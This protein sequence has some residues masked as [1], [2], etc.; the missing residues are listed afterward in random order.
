MINAYNFEKRRV[1]IFDCDGVLFDSKAS[2]INYYN[3]LLSKFGLPPLKENDVEFIHMH[4]ADECIYHLFSNSPH[5]KD[6]LKYR[7]EMP[8]DQFIKD[9]VMEDG[10]ID[11]L[12]FLKPVYHI[13]MATNRSNSIPEVLSYFKL[14]NFFDLVVSSLDVANPKPDPECI[15][16]II[17]FF[18]VTKEDVVYI[19][20]SKLDEL[21]AINAGVKFIAYKNPSLHADFHA[22]SLY[23]VKEII[24]KLLPPNDL[25]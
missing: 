9:M 5:L 20:D 19:G 2:N 18:R 11:L 12:T 23:E 15:I 1:A 17:E 10:L 24:G 4:T 22:G 8:I 16:K 14:Q 21:T 6:A 25:G 7:W 13:A 3:H